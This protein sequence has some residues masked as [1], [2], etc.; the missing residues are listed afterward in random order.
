MPCTV[1]RN[2]QWLHACLHPTLPLHRSHQAAAGYRSEVDTEGRGS[3]PSRHGRGALPPRLLP[4][5]LVFFLLWLGPLAAV[6]K[7]AQLASEAEYKNVTRLVRRGAFSEAVQLMGELRLPPIE[8]ASEHEPLALHWQGT[9]VRR[10][11]RSPPGELI[12]AAAMLASVLHRLDRVT[13]A[14][15]RIQ[16]VIAF[17]GARARLRSSTAW[18]VLTVRVAPQHSTAGRDRSTIFSTNCIAAFGIVSK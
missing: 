10:C 9:L 6:T 4:R 5:C 17:S 12:A 3:Y 2:P 18:P 7:V 1:T 15:D 16:L 13:E 14:L 8:S 11:H